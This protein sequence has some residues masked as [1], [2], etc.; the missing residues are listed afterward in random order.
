VKRISF[1]WWNI[2]GE[3]HTSMV[4]LSMSFT[5]SKV[6]DHGTTNPIVAR[7]SL[8]V[9]KILS[10]CNLPK[11]KFD[12]VGDLYLSSLQKKLLRCWEIEDRFRIEF[13]A[14]A[15]AYKPPSRRGQAVNLPQIVRLEEE[16]HNFLYE[17]KNYIRDL[18][19]V[20]NLLY[21]TA[22]SEASE[23]S[24][25][26]K[27]G[28]SLIEFATKAFSETDSKTKFLKES[29]KSVQYLIDFRNAVEH[30]GGYSGDLRIVNFTLET[31]G[32]IT[33]PTWYR[34]KNGQPVDACA[35]IRADMGTAIEGL[36]TLG[37]DIFVSWAADNLQAPKLMQLRQI[38]AE[39]RDPKCPIKW[40]VASSQQLE[41]ILRQ[42]KN[43]R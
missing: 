32:R 29:A 19:K 22:F 39:K 34:E 30:P 37:E 3:K 23:F 38:P 7:L 6:S 40:V 33:E 18:L 43:K 27:G 9:F 21:D 20:V 14:A 42:Q 10:Q 31:D 36:L 17:A 4:G 13:N 24:R 35:S 25:A 28:Q 26:K 41:D 5:I 15:D 2:I 12:K 16:C 8:Q 11:E 1:I